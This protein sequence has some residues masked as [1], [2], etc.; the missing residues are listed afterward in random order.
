MT[1]TLEP[2]RRARLLAALL[3]CAAPLALAQ[4]DAVAPAHDP[5]GGWRVSPSLSILGVYER[6]RGLSVLEPEAATDRPP[7]ESLGRFQPALALGLEASRSGSRGGFQGELALLGRD[8]LDADARA[9][10]FDG[11]AHAYRALGGHFRLELDESLRVER[12]EDLPR[13]DFQRQQAQA[14]LEYRG[15]SGPAFRLQVADRRLGLPNARVLDVAQRSLA[16]GLLA[17]P[18]P[19]TSLEAKGLF[20]RFGATAAQRNHLGAAFEAARVQAGGLV[21]LHYHFTVALGQA[22]GAEAALGPSVLPVSIRVGAAVDFSSQAVPEPPLVSPVLESIG[23]LPAMP[24]SDALDD[25]GE[26]W[27]SRQEHLVSLYAARRLGARLRLMVR[28]QLRWRS[29]REPLPEELAGFDD[30]RWHL[31]A[32]LRYTLGRHSALIAQAARAHE[33]GN[34]AVPE[35]VR[36]QVFFGLQLR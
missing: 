20:R 28:G 15:A 24:L 23:E 14:T 34:P 3:A 36:S 19:G 32:T 6:D 27:P 4:S 25:E 12:R 33:R 18:S 35:L 1:N 8:P 31:R 9:F 11:R 21:A 16:L 17:T 2:G 13:G 5:M 29:G 22:R 26:S 10:L 30:R 7:S